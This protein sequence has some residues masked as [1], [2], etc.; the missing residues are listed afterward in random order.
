MVFGFR[1]LHTRLEVRVLFVLA[2]CIGPS[3]PPPTTHGKVVHAGQTT[4]LVQHDDL[5]GRVVTGVERYRWSGQGAAAGDHVDLWLDEDGDEVERTQLREHLDAPSTH[6]LVG[7]VVNVDGIRVMVDHEAIPDVMGAMVMGFGLSPWEVEPLE[8]GST[9]EATLVGS[10]YGWQLADVKVTGKTEKVVRTDI[11]PLEPGQVLPA[12]QLVAEDGSTI[13]VGEG[14]GVPTAF[15]YI[16]TRCPDPS[17]CP[18]IAMRMKALQGRLKGARIVTVS[19]DPDFDTPE[20]LAAW[21]STVGAD[22]KVWRLA[23]AEPVDLQ[24]LAMYGGQHVTA[25]GGRISHLHRLLIL[26]ADGKLIERYDDNAWPLDRVAEQLNG[27]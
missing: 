18:A 20:R 3:G 14:Q 7:T 9:I 24:A 2:G 19:I 5:R 23:R 10:D 13:T 11:E 15:T 1:L 17:F 4:L 26:D 22:T 16:Y 6:P 12:T 27:G 8:V 25:D 21:G